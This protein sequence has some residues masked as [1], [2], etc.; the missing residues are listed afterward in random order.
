MI[1]CIIMFICVVLWVWLIIITSEHGK[2]HI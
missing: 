1:K 2:N